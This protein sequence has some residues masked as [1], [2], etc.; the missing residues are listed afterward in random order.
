MIFS[1]SINRDLMDLSAWPDDVRIVFW[2]SQSIAASTYDN[3]Y[4]RL[5]QQLMLK[6]RPLDLSSV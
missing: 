6:I 3:M 5:V 1:R 2:R 4:I